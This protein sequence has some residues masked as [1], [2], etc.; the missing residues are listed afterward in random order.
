AAKPWMEDGTCPPSQNWTEGQD[1]T[2][3]CWAWGNPQ[4]RLVCTKDGETFPVGVPRPVTRAHAGIYHCRATNPLGAAERNIT[5][6]VQCEWGGGPGVL[7]G[8]GGPGGHGGPK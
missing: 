1:G 4:P 6:S 2:L 8:S 7:E 3:Q 5:V